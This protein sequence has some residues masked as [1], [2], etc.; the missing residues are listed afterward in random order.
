MEAMT[1]REL[2]EAVGGTLIGPAVN[3]EQSVTHV[4]TDSRNIHPGK[5]D[6]S[7]VVL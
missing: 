2:L 5:S 6:R 1:V 3:L 7:H 4:D